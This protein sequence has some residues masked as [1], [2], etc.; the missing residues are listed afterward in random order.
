MSR[1]KDNY[2]E[3]QKA[4]G[5]YSKYRFYFFD[6][7]YYCGEKWRKRG[8]RIDGGPVVI[9]YRLFCIILP[10][11]AIPSRLSALLNANL[12]ISFSIGLA[13]PVIFCQIRYRG[14]R[15]AALMKHFSRST[16]LKGILLSLVHITLTTRTGATTL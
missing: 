3:R 2:F 16:W 1:Y 4:K 5:Q 9:L 8:A 6:Y 12:A 7:L 10:L 14:K 11:H 13:L 15:T